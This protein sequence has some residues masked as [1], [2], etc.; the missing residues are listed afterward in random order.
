[1][2]SEPEMVDGKP[3]KE[4]RQK[5]SWTRWLEKNHDK[6]PGIWL[7]LAKKDSGLRSVSR[8]DALDAALCYGWIDGQAKSEGQSTWLQKFTPRTKRSIW[9]KVNRARVEKLI[10]S[11]EMRPAGQA[12]IERAKE[13]GR[14]E[15]AYD[16]PKTI[17]VP[18]DLKAAFINNR[19]AAAFFEKLDSRNRYAVLFRI[20]TAKKP[21]TRAKRIEQFV[22]ML[23]RGEKLH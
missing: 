11:G 16:S 2:K 18:D 10:D 12:E 15:S 5:T 8:D 14:W 13:D 20:H 6:S 7:R 4:F 22:A 3:V 17:T 9:S 23:S 21:E 19:N 1:M